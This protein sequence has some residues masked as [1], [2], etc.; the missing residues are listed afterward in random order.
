VTQVSSST[1]FSILGVSDGCA[2]ITAKLGTQSV[3]KTVRVVYIGG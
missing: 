2:I 3:S 1:P